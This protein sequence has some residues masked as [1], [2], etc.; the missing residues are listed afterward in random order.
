[1]DVESRAEYIGL[2]SQCNKIRPARRNSLWRVSEADVALLPINALR[3]FF[4]CI[5]VLAADGPWPARRGILAIQFRKG[6]FM[7][8]I[9]HIGYAVRNVDEKKDLMENLLGF[10]FAERKEYDRGGGGLTA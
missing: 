6:K 5:H 2:S 1:M 9:D 3:S 10:K 7:R 8:E 4:S